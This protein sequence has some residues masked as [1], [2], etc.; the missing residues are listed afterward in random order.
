MVRCDGCPV[1]QG[2]EG[3]VGV[4]RDCGALSSGDS[5]YRVEGGS[6]EMLGIAHLIAAGIYG[7]GMF[8]IIRFKRLRKK[9]G[10]GGPGPSRER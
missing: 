3:I 8:Y 10:P 6:L 7:A 2:A 4:H 5:L 9:E 1:Y